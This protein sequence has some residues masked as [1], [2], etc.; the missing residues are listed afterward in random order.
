L[1][2][3]VAGLSNPVEHGAIQLWLGRLTHQP[4]LHRRYW[5]H[6]VKP[7]RE[8]AIESF[9]EAAARGQVADARDADLLI[10]MLAG[11]LLYRYF[12]TPQE[13]RKDESDEQWL[14]RLADLAERL[15]SPGPPSGDG[16]ARS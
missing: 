4:K 2:V 16:D 5:E 6:R 12:L 10:D 14:D 11:V 9:R 3:A 7:R 8:R 13:L 1:R 15:L